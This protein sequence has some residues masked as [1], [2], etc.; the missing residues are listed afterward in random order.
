LP[1]RSIL[2]IWFIGSCK[3]ELFKFLFIVIIIILERQFFL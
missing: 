3:D 2:C 1:T